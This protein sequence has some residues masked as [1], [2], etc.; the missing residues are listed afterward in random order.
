[1]FSSAALR[2]SAIWSVFLGGFM[3]TLLTLPDSRAAR[4]DVLRI[5]TSGTLNSEHEAKEKGALM[6]LKAF[7]KD[8]TGLDNEI[9]REKNW[10]EMTEKLAKGE[11][12][13]G[14]YMG[15][16]F[17][18]AQEKHAKLKPLALAVNIYRYP[19][20]YVVTRKDAKVEKLA[21]LQGQ[22]ISISSESSRLVRMFV[23]REAEA[24]GKKSDAFF[25]NVASPDSV[26]D[27][28][29]DVVDGKV[30]AAAV[31][32]AALEAFKRRKPGRFKQ[33]KEV[34]QSQQ[35]PPP[36]I[37]QY[38]DVLDA[39]T[40]QKFERGLLNADK[41]EAGQ[42]TLTLFHLT[43]FEKSPADFEKVL[44]EC[45]KTYPPTSPAK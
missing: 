2:R 45:R 23:D 37:A 17:A 43:G 14:V 39:A 12:Q 24:A 25:T 30:Q 13:V 15:Y 29:D 42:T 20:V 44:A 9:V 10:Q 32:R 6:S 3:G 21:G 11:I 27:A 4:L 16:E 35:M 8:E 41:K 18:W 38:G 19:V 22:S 1:M 7:I 40:L 26:E 33:L 34:A 36:V 31:D 28:L 5:G